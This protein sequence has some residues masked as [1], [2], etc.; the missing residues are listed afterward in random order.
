MWWV[1]ACKAVC[2]FSNR[3]KLLFVVGISPRTKPV[4][5]CRMRIRFAR[6]AACQTVR[7]RSPTP[8][9][10]GKRAHHSLCFGDEAPG[11]PLAEGSFV[12]NAC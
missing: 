7:L 6:L 8:P 3:D 9:V 11:W 5:T 12:T 2:A 4:V 10:W 1:S